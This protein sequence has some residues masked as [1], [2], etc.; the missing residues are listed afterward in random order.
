MATALNGTDYTSEVTDADLISAESQD[1]SASSAE[2]TSPKY[3]P[4]LSGP[5]WILL[6]ILVA[7]LARWVF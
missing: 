3:A 6:I 7:A 1:G 2:L 4:A 5:W